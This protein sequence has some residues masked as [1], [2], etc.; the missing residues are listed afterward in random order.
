M[1]IL[2][3]LYLCRKLCY[4]GCTRDK[5]NEP[6]MDGIQEVEIVIF[7]W[8]FRSR[9]L[10]KVWNVLDTYYDLYSS[11]C[12]TVLQDDILDRLLSNDMGLWE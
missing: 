11:M 5:P 10:P 2:D 1:G 3:T 12:L 8:F 9:Y 6:K 7:I 4:T